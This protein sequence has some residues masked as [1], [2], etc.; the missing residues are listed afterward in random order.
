MGIRAGSALGIW[1]PA[2][3]AAMAHDMMAVT[4]VRTLPSIT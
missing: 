2:A 1:A 4:L 3:W